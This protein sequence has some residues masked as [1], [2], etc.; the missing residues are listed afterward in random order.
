MIAKAICFGIGIVTGMLILLGVL[1]AVK[2]PGFSFLVLAVCLCV[3]L[4][5]YSYMKGK[6]DEL[7]K[8]SAN[9]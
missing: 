3:A 9:D 8:D 6:I 4:M 2:H 1:F 7:G 5:R